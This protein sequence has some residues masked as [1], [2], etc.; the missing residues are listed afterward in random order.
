MHLFLQVWDLRNNEL[1]YEMAG[2]MD[3]ITGLE[4]SPNGHY[5]LSNSMDD[6]GQGQRG[7]FR[8]VYG[9]GESFVQLVL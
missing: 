6:T 2:H 4:V 7:G 9:G 5:L 3:T 1:C 8:V